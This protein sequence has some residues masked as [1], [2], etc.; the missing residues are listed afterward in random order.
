V[1]SGH[2]L[3]RSPQSTPGWI[4]KARL[5]ERF[6][7]AC[8]T[9][10]TPGLLAALDKGGSCDGLVFRILQ[11]HVEQETEVLWRREM[12]LPGYVAAFLDVETTCGNINALVFISDHAAEKIIPDIRRSEQI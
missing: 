11:K 10:Q 8:G 3:R 9:L 4:P 12:P 2:S 6:C 1:G 5:A 7:G